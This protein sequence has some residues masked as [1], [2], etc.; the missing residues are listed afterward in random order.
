MAPDETTEFER[1]NR[2]LL[3]VYRAGTSARSH[4][5]VASTLL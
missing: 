4:R 2:R 1:K 5:N 3:R